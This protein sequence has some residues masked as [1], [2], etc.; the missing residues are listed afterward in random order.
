MPTPQTLV[1]LNWM[2]LSESLFNIKGS[3]IMLIIAE[4]EESHM[5]FYIT[6]VQAMLFFFTSYT[7]DE[8]NT[9][10]SKNVIKYTAK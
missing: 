8:L 3:T 10:T 4:K 7:V 5:V 1:S 6:E 9:T 2:G